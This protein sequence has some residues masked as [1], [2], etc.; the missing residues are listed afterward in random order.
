MPRRTRNR[1]A[2]AK[3][4]PIR[5]NAA[6]DNG[7]GIFNA[8]SFTLNNSLIASNQAIGTNGSALTDRGDV[9]DGGG[10]YNTAALTLTN[11]AVSGNPPPGGGPNGTDGAPQPAPY[12]G[13]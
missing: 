9:G 5:G 1:P 13:G 11:T 2:P 12:S 8:G 3:N 7:G 4:G 10:A 6:D